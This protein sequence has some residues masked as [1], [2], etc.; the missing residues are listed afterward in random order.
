VV[1]VLPRP[2]GSGGVVAVWAAGVDLAS[3]NTLPAAPG[4][5]VVFRPVVYTDGPLRCRPGVTYRSLDVLGNERWRVEGCDGILAAPRATV[6]DVVLDGRG[7]GDVGVASSSS[8]PPA[9]G[10]RLFD[11]EIRRY[12]RAAISQAHGQWSNWLARRDWRG[13]GDDA[14]VITNGLHTRNGLVAGAD[15]DSDTIIYGQDLRAHNVTWL[16]TGP[17]HAVYAKGRGLRLD[18][19]CRF[20]RCDRALSLRCGNTIIHASFYECA[21]AINY[22]ANDVTRLG[23]RI[24]IGPGVEMLDC[25]GD[26]L[27]YLDAAPVEGTQIV[28]AIDAAFNGVTI[29]G[30]GALIDFRDLT[31]KA[32]R[33]VAIRALDQDDAN[34]IRPGYDP[35]LTTWA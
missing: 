16:E 22:I 8:E 3:T 12:R 5:V 31:T 6:R 26:F 34:L 28:P 29:R 15:G 33:P 23:G 32:R 25:G 13:T 9:P 27:V 4:D 7:V 18:R 30:G 2:Y 20:V 19:H 11:Y 14:W 1:P 35:A 17:D 21:D 10:F 24:Q